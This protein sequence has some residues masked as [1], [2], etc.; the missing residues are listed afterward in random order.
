MPITDAQAYDVQ[1]LL[2]RALRQEAPVVGFKLGYTS[3]VMREAM[4][5]ADPNYGRL[6]RDMVKASPACIGSLTQPKVEPEFAVVVGT[7]L[8]IDAVHASMEVVDSVWADYQFTWAHNTADGSSAACAVIGD[9]IPVDVSLT[10]VTIE[11]MSS[12]GESAAVRAQDAGIDL[13]ESL[14]WLASQS[15]VPR[16]LQPMDVVLTGG[17]LAPFDLLDG[18]WIETTF[19]SGSWVTRVRV[20]RNESG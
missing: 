10:D 5:I 6:T 9:E 2:H 4:G 15:D 13:D 8:T 20:E 16:A 18:G 7:N 14:S 12:S 19:R 3:S 11:M 17:L 1:R